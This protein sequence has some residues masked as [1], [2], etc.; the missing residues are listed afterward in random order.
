MFLALVSLLAC[1]SD[2]PCSPGYAKYEG[3]CYALDGD[4]DD[5]GDEA[6][7]AN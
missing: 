7:A 2:A 1:Q 3:T 4:D 6:D 5:S